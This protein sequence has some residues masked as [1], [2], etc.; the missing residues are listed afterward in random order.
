MQGGDQDFP[1]DNQYL[2]LALGVKASYELPV[3]SLET[4]EVEQTIEGFLFKKAKQ[5]N[6][7]NF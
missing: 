7:D 6:V 5:N 3:G 4:L 2:N 1:R